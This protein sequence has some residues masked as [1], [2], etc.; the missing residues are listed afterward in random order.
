MNSKQISKIEDDHKT[1]N[2]IRKA[3]DNNEDVEVK[4]GKDGEIKVLAGK[5]RRLI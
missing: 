4:R 5:K 1:M 3:L 2:A